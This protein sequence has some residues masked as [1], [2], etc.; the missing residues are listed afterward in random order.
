MINPYGIQKR[1]GEKKAGGMYLSDNNRG[2]HQR[3]DTRAAAPRRT[4]RTAMHGGPPRGARGQGPCPGRG[5]G[6]THGT[7]R[8]GNPPTAGAI[9]SLPRPLLLLLSRLPLPF[10][11]RDGDGARRE[12]PSARTGLRACAA[13]LLLLAQSRGV[14][15]CAARKR[16]SGAWRQTRRQRR[17]SGDER[18]AAGG[19]MADG[20]TDGRRRTS[21]AAAGASSRSPSSCSSRTRRPSSAPSRGPSRAGCR[22]RAARGGGGPAVNRASSRRWAG[23]HLRVISA[24]AG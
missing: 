14:P 1:C 11:A 16:G 9:S 19:R 21:L 5:G 17:A 7:R 20:R 24:A 10:S 23:R 2:P 15:V 4:P 8:A 22:L 3:F 6:A 18:G 12:R 13:H